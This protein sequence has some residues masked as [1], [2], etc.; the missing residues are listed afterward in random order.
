M[1]VSAATAALVRPELPAGIGL[2]DL[3]VHR[4]KDLPEEERLYQLVIDDLPDDFPPLQSRVGSFLPPPLTGFIGRQQQ[5]AEAA[6]LL[7]RCRLVTFTGPGGTGKTRLA[8]EVAATVANRFRDG[9]WFVSLAAIT[10]TALVPSAVLAVLEVHDTGRDTPHSLLLQY[11]ADKELL[12]VLDNLE[13]LPDA[14]PLVADLLGS[15]TGCVFLATSRAPLRISGEQE[16]GVPPLVVP[17]PRQWSS[18]DAV[19]KNE[20]VTLFVERA[21]AVR[22]DFDLSADNA[23]TV[24]ELVARLDGL[25]LAI[26]LAASRIKLLAPAALLAR[27]DNRLLA[28]GAQDLPA[29][30]QTLSATIEW[31]YDLL[32]DTHRRLMDCFSVFVGGAMLTEAEAVCSDGSEMDVLDGLSVLVSNSLLLSS[33]ADGE[34]RFSMLQTLREFAHERLGAGGEEA[35]ARVRHA[36]AYVALA[37]DAEAYLLTRESRHWL[38]RLEMD[39]DNLR[40]AVAF[41]I[42]TGRTNLAW[43]LVGALWRFFHM[44]GHLH[45]ATEMMRSALALPGGDPALRSKALV[46]AGGVAYW[47]GDVESS[48]QANQENLAICRRLG[49]KRLLAEALYSISFPCALSGD[50]TGADQALQESLGIFEEL[51]DRAGLADVHWGMGDAA[52]NRADYETARDFFELA[53]S[54]Y[55]QIDNAFGLGWSHYMYGKSAFVLGDIASAE[56]HINKGLA[57]FARAGDVSAFTLH[58]FDLAA[59]ALRSG[60][61]VRAATLLG[62]ANRMV[63][64]TGE[65]LVALEVNMAPGLDTAVVDRLQRELPGE[66]DQGGAMSIEAAVDFA[67]EAD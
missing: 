34:P 2:R 23:G 32:D 63:E 20:A 44:R 53:I 33:D 39:V 51:E 56:E 42:D 16:Y 11:L 57:I 3:G 15:Q 9:V 13:Q 7:E 66:F 40:A 52:F 64:T 49:D 30:H 46:A 36:E 48:L 28:G 43:R 31:S 29:R 22:P 67:L 25:P 6:A 26:E 14:A 60:D 24:A 17:D 8:L 58:L 37:E 4:L 12:L 61:R 1:V 55:E 65:N 59:I 45:E 38:D 18:V 50:F 5:V 27:L 47:R 62:A 35:E 19:A 41:A 10:D 21:R 54:D